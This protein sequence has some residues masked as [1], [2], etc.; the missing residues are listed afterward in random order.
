[1]MLLFFISSVMIHLGR[2]PISGKR[3]PSDRRSIKE[4]NSIVG[5]LFHICERKTG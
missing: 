4:I 3:L 5:I 2:N 1:M